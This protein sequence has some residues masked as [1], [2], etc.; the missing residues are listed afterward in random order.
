MARSAVQKVRVRARRPDVPSKSIPISRLAAIV[1]VAAFVVGLDLYSPAL[2]APFV[3]DDFTLPFQQGSQNLLAW[4]SGVRPFLMLTYWLNARISGNS[5]LGYHLLNLVI[6]AVNTGL[7]FLVLSRLLSLSGGMSPRAVRV[8]SVIGAAVFLV[9]PL[10]TESVSYIAG[11]SESL[12]A[13]FVLLAY[14]VFL[15]RRQET[16]SWVETAVVLALFAFGVS[17]KEN[18]VSLAGILLL[19][20]VYWPQ[21]FSTRGLRNNWRFYAAMAAGAIVAAWTVFRML[22]AAP[23]AGF[24]LRDV[25]WYQYGFT[26]ARAFFTYVRLAAIPAG[27]SIDHDYPVS[28]TILEHGAIFYLAALA[29]L[30]AVCYAWRRRYPLVCFGLF[31]T[32]ILLAPTSSIVPIRD[33]LVERRM[34]LPLMGL[35]LIGCEIA[36]HIRVRRLTGYAACGAML[37][38]FCVLC[39]QRN[40]LWAEPSQL[41]AEAALESAGKGRPYANLV[42]QLV[43]ERRC[44]VAIPYLKHAEQVLPNDYFVQLAWGR[45]LECVGQKDEA[46][47]KLLR[48][49][50]IWQSSEV[51]RLIGLLYGEMGRPVEAGEALRR[52]V[53]LDPQSG[54]ARDALA[55]WNEWMKEQAAA[56]KARGP[57]PVFAPRGGTAPGGDATDAQST[58]TRQT[59]RMWDLTTARVHFRMLDERATP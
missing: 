14:V 4:V 8:A 30:I 59:M 58:V 55:L 38:I 37:A 18:A 56:E 33:P 6:H 2:G 23:S 51:Y 21:A 57:N 24:S 32:L 20:D 53:A 27:Q 28:H 15:Y 16:I 19:T 44:S 41:W 47:R 52:A 25:T 22:A 48:A 26:Q 31:L 49:A 3:F 46:L 40:L 11:R 1:T 17:T 39:Y 36:R 12:A 45:T 35:I 5:P 43:E 9:H 34:Y 29:G 10:Q 54:R 7:V 50:Q 42:D 13:M